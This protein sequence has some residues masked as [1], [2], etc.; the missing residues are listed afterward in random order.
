[1]GGSKAPPETPGWPP[2]GHPKTTLFSPKNHPFPTLFSPAGPPGG[3]W[4]L[5][6]GR[7]VRPFSIFECRFSNVELRAKGS[8]TERCTATA[9]RLS[10][11]GRGDLPPDPAGEPRPTCHGGI[12]PQNGGN[13]NYKLAGIVRVRRL[14]V[15]RG[16]G[17][18]GRRGDQ[19][20]RGDRVFSAALQRR[21]RG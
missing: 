19:T 15:G 9:I 16:E 14:S 1:M 20:I 18:V 11:P 2:A 7:W 6:A 4:G 8:M 3:F 12:I 5:L 21:R 17:E 10:K 13:V